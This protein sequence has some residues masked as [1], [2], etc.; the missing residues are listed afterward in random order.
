MGRAAGPAST[1]LAFSW[2]VEHGYIITAYYLLGFVAILGA[3]PAF[4]IVEGQGPTA[5][6]ENSD[7]DGEEEDMDDSA[8]FLPNESAV[9][10]EFEDDYHYDGDSGAS[11]PLLGGRDDGTKYASIKT[12]GR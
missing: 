2:G 5:S 4:M 7:S 11:R 6:V 10:D 8:V 1:G 3:V 12:G 9:E